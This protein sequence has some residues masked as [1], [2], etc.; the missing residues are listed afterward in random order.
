[1]LVVNANISCRDGCRGVTG[2]GLRGWA[3]IQVYLIPSKNF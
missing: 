1:M 3:R 2:S